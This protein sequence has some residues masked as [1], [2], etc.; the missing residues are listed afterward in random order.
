[1]PKAE[2][3][4]VDRRSEVALVVWNLATMK[5]VHRYDGYREGAFL[6][7]NE[8]L[9][10]AKSD[11]PQDKSSRSEFADFRY[12][13]GCSLTSEVDILNLDG[14]VQH[15]LSLI[16]PDPDTIGSKWML[17]GDGKSLLSVSLHRDKR[18]RLAASIVA[19]V[20][21]VEAG[22]KTHESMLGEPSE[23]WSSMLSRI[24]GVSHDGSLLVLETEPTYPDVHC[25]VEIWDTQKGRMM[26]R[27]NVKV[28][29]VRQPRNEFHS[30]KGHLLTRDNYL[31]EATKGNVAFWDVQ[32]GE[33]VA[34]YSR[35]ADASCFLAGL[36]CNE[37]QAVLAGNGFRFVQ[38][39]DWEPRKAARKLE[40]EG[41]GLLQNLG[42]FQEKFPDSMEQ[43]SAVERKIGATSFAAKGKSQGSE[44][45]CR[46]MGDRTWQIEYKLDADATRLKTRL[47]EQL[48]T[49]S[50][51]PTTNAQG[52]MQMAWEF[53]GIKLREAGTGMYIELEIASDGRTTV[54]LTNLTLK[55]KLQEA[56]AELQR[57]IAQA[58]PR[59]G[60]IAAGAG[61]LRVGMTFAEVL[62]VLGKPHRTDQ[63]N[64]PGK[65]VVMWTYYPEPGKFI[66][67][68]FTNG[69]LL[70]WEVGNR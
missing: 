18:Q 60:S 35:V 39:P 64:A 24:R 14:D 27:P 50:A 55:A 31:L 3:E 58:K 57:Q 62:A 51:G 7:E 16:S 15:T 25:R 54:I 12:R 48:G 19:R 22:E 49:P 9:L 29:R 11:S 6:P 42:D 45:L 68:G 63:V 61:Q 4:F 41:F 10:L 21:D 23:S 44:L 38:L 36:V 70:E 53:P 52:A 65:E 32:S 5:Q 17:S 20:F 2:N 30:Y 13:T 26:S 28:F 67:L 56:L 37:R 40:A 47:L 59:R 46:F 33:I 34:A 8:M 66:G 69:A 1:M 43:S